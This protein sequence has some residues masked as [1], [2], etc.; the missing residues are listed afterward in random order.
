MAVTNFP[1]LLWECTYLQVVDGVGEHGEHAEVVVHHHVGDVTVD[2]DLS[3]A[4]ALQ[5]REAQ[6][7]AKNIKRGR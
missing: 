6:E 5:N 2:E 3:G 7:T 4:Q 1:P